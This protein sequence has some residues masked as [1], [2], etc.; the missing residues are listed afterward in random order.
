MPQLDF[1]TFPSQLFWLAISFTLLYV[2]VARF[3]L[4]RIRNV[5]QH[6][7]ETI[8]DDLKQAEAMK[9]DAEKAQAFSTGVLTE[10]REKANKSLA[11]AATKIKK[12]SNEEHAKLDKVLAERLTEAERR[13]GTLRE[14]ASGKMEPVIAEVSQLLVEKLI[15]VKLGS[16]EANKAVSASSVKQ[17]Q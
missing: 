13:I 5:L 8:S 10:A 14:E 9:Q 1:A 16:D 15:G 4:P 7:E 12:T 17:G 2:I 11:D 6:R 3:S